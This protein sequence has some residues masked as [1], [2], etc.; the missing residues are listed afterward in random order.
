ME[1]GS[2]MYCLWI[3]KDLEDADIGKKFGSL[4]VASK[5]NVT[6]DTSL[7]EVRIETFSEIIESANINHA[8]AMVERKQLHLIKFLCVCAFEID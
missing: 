7:G 2:Y 5:D 3:A 6:L 4:T 1:D 8:K